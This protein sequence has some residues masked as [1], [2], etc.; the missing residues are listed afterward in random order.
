MKKIV[1]LLL[2]S[3][4]V[5]GLL[6]GCGSNAPAETNQ[7]ASAQTEKKDDKI[8]ELK[9]YTVGGHQPTNYDAWKAEM[10]AYLEEKIG[11]HLDIEV[12]G[13]GDWDQRR[14]MIVSTNEPY[15]IMFTEN[16]NY[17]ENVN[18]GAF[19]DIS[20]LLDG[21]PALRDSIP[22]DYWDACTVGNGLY[23]VPTYKDSSATYFFVYDEAL[24][25]ATGMDYLDAH[26]FPEAVEV[27]E[28]MQQITTDLHAAG[29]PVC[30]LHQKGLD[31]IYQG[32]YD[33]VSSGCPAIGVSYK[34]GKPEVVS[35]FEQED[36]IADL[37]ILED[38]YQKGIIN[39]DANI[40]TEVSGYNAC[41]VA[42]GWPF[43]GQTAWGMQLGKG[44]GRLKVA[45][46]QWG[47]TVLSNSTVQGSLNCIS[48][49]CQH[50]EKALQLLELVNTDS[51]VRDML[52]YGLEG[53]NFEYTA[54]GKVKKLLD[55]EPWPMAGYTQGTFFKVT[56]EV[57]DM[58]P[59]GYDWANEE[60]KVQNENAIASPILGFSLDM[61]PIAS[62][63][64]AVK[65]IFTE[66]C[67][68]L[69]TGSNPDARE[70]MLSAMYDAGLQT[71]IDEVQRQIDVW[72][73]A[74]K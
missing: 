43:A 69:M 14:N 28:A 52:Y 46:A 73:A 61:A 23:A 36:V 58:N 65:A 29:E 5:L 44:K 66:W 71:V 20:G 30:R 3:V 22:Q 54:D 31:A 4:M 26:T 34:G 7:S 17:Y 51:K 35:V 38:M 2:A 60:V 1:A 45:V 55:A 24:A 6:A 39:A 47:D 62:E 13:W 64:K 48:A 33:D 11:V 32:K 42:Q 68:S 59:E 53:E 19:A 18:M 16:A 12:V 74:K 37:E 49:S 56:P 63:L 8:V 10:D 27:M 57:S 70:Q 21:V 40:L 72:A 67:A 41:G 15:D 25:D 50:P 9:W